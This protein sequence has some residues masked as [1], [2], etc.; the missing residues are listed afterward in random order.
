MDALMTQLAGSQRRL[1]RHQYSQHIKVFKRAIIDAGQRF[2]V[3]SRASL[4]SNSLTMP[5]Y[6]RPDLTPHHRLTM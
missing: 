1:L 6:L 2:Q 5:Y 4:P 3:S